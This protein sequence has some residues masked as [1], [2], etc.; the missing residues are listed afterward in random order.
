MAIRSTWSSLTSQINW[1]SYHRMLCLRLRANGIYPMVVEWVQAFLS[2]IQ[3][4]VRV[5]CKMPDFR[6]HDQNEH[7]HSSL[8][9]WWGKIFLFPSLGNRMN[10]RVLSL[11]FLLSDFHLLTYATENRRIL[12]GNVRNIKSPSST[13]RCYFQIV[14]LLLANFTTD[15]T[16]YTRKLIELKGLIY[17]YWV[18]I[19]M[20]RLK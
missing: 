6:R 20:R 15:I 14:F 1:L 9:I 13:T 19:W 12:A 18:I 4:R 2:D 3:F 10:K 16:K 17:A 8:R 11:F 7:H 5:K